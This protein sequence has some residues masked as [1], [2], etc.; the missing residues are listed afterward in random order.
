MRHLLHRDAALPGLSAPVCER[1]RAIPL[2]YVEPDHS[3]YARTLTAF[4]LA[5]AMVATVDIIGDGAA[6]RKL[7]T[8]GCQGIPVVNAGRR[9]WGGRQ[10]GPIMQFAGTS[11]ERRERAS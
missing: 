8:I 10:P 2:V 4:S 5:G 7:N 3:G 6:R 9:I 11:V 1:G